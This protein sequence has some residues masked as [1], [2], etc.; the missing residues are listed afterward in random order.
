MNP[1]II[2]N[3]AFTKLSPITKG[4]LCIVYILLFSLL[5]K[6]WLVALNLNLFL[7]LIC[8]YLKEDAIGLIASIKRIWFLLLIVGLFQ[9]FIG[10]NFDFF[11]GLSAV[12]KIMGIY[13]TATLYTRVSTQNE[14]LYFWEI[15]FKPLKL[16]GFSSN[17]L[18]LTMVIAIRFLPVFIDEIERIRI[19]QIAR[20][21]KLSK[22]SIVSAIN[23]MPL[24]IPVLTQAIM[25]SEE[26][27]DAMEV[28]GYVPNRP[29]GRYKSYALGIYDFVAFVI[30]VTT[31][32]LLTWKMLA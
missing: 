17:E 21:A 15:C 6:T 31:I 10:K 18:A 25:R 29:R 13:L 2:N 3:S 11:A 1:Q 22:N 4:L 9:G 8:F 23:F 26:L 12:F 5:C 27:A 28:R 20:G 24:L 14:L 16:F 7:I 19:A 32:G 30:M